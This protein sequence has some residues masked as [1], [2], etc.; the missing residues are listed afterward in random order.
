MSHVDDLIESLGLKEC[1][2]VRVGDLL[3][4][5]YITCPLSNS[6][7]LLKVSYIFE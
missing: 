2:N 7:N 6:I 4:P 1:E 3:G 5:K